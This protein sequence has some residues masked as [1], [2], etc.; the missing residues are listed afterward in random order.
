M[1]KRTHTHIYVH[2][3]TRGHIHNSTCILIYV[4]SIYL[5]T[6]THT[7][8]HEQTVIRQD[9]SAQ[10]QRLFEKRWRT[11]VKV[12][13]FA[14]VVGRAEKE[15]RHGWASKTSMTCSSRDRSMSCACLPLAQLLRCWMSSYAARGKHSGLVCSF[16]N[17]Q[18][19]P[20][21]SLT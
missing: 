2:I 11:I 3:F 17:A 4:C 10:L 9:S 6:Y 8:T 7:H 1:H 16:V 19:R 5:Y 14:S 15:A 12:K 20:K 21:Y 13:T 18:T